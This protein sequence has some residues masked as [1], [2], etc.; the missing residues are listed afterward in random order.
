M[1]TTPGHKGNVNQNHT[2]IP[3]TPGRM[4]IIKNTTNNKCWQ[5]YREKGTLIHCWW[6]CKLVRPL[7]ETLWGHLKKLN[8]DLP[9]D[10]TIPTPSDIPEGMRLKLL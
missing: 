1:L 9:Y 6:K 2:R 5:G 3:P 7:W 4:A 10:P 8:I